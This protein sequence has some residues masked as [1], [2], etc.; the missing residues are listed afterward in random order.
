MKTRPIIALLLFGMLL[1]SGCAGAPQP[2]AASARAYN[3]N[4]PWIRANRK[5]LDFNLAVDRIALKPAAKVYAKLPQP[6]QNGAG[7]FFANLWLPATVLNDL[8]QGK[9]AAAGRDSA[10]FLINTLLGAGGLMDVATA[11]DFPPHREDFGQTLAVWGVPPGPYLVLPLLG[12]SNLRDAFGLVP[13]NAVDGVSVLESPARSYARGV[14][15]LDARADLLGLDETLALQPDAY[16]FLREGYRQRRAQLI[17]DG[18]PPGAPDDAQ[19][20]DELLHDDA[21]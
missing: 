17:H 6:V 10:R 3:D 13:Q 19:L 14:R 21:D 12:P 8:L 15:L 20:I 5:I 1:L 2:E 7:N 18:P 16:L 9:L 11:L 4:D